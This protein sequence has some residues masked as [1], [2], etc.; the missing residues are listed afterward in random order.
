MDQPLDKSTQLSVQR[1]LLS[2][3]RTLMSW[4]RT[5]VSLAGFGFTIYKFFQ[6]LIEEGIL[7]GHFHG[8]RIVG[9]FLI[10]FGFSSLLIGIIEFF[11]V[12]KTVSPNERVW[13]PFRFATVIF[14]MLLALVEASLFV[15]LLINPKF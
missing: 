15:T 10:G 12:H 11:V 14:A 8:A 5:S 3:E 2:N 1:T 4:I 9:L 13:S 7:H 6:S